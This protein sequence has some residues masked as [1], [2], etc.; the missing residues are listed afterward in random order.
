[1]MRYLA[2]QGTTHKADECVMHRLHESVDLQQLAQQLSL[3]ATTGEAVAAVAVLPEVIRPIPLYIRPA[4]WA[5]WWLFE[6]SDEEVNEAIEQNKKAA[7][8]QFVARLIA[9]AAKRGGRPGGPDR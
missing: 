7:A 2:L 5:V 1:M 3:A 4:A 9:E 6:L 8:S